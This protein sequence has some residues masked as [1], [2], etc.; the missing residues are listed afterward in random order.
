MRVPDA[1]AYLSARE[2]SAASLTKTTSAARRVALRAHRLMASSYPASEGVRTSPLMDLRKDSKSAMVNSSPWELGHQR[3][4][5]RTYMRLTPATTFLDCLTLV[6]AS[7]SSET[8]RRRLSVWFDLS[9]S[10]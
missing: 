9:A 2:T 3:R 8:Q 4:M 10:S 5:A 1:V 7:R 6:C